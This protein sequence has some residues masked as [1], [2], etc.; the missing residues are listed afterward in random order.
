[1]KLFRPAAAAV[2]ILLAAAVSP[3]SAEES[4]PAPEELRAKVETA[5]SNWMKNLPPA[6]WRIRTNEEVPGGTRTM[7]TMAEKETI[8]FAGK[9]KMLKEPDPSSGSQLH[10]N[11][12]QTVRAVN[13][14]YWFTVTKKK[15][16]EEWDIVRVQ[17]N[18]SETGP[19]SVWQ[20]GLNVE[21]RSP[22]FAFREL[23]Y[24]FCI[25]GCYTVLDIL[26]YPGLV[27]ESVRE[28][29]D[30]GTS[31]TFHLDP[32][33]E[34]AAAFIPI[35]NGTVT[36]TG[37]YLIKDARFTMQ[38]GNLFTLENEY[39]EG[40][41][42]ALVKHTETSYNGETPGTKRT[43]S[44]ETG[45]LP[46]LPLKRFTLSRYGLPEPDYGYPSAKGVRIVL[47]TF[48]GVL[49]LIAL[50]SIFRKRRSEVKE[51]TP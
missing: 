24:P 26:R 44:I 37:G 39:S 28:E 30:G 22:F 49:I 14:R 15:S 16:D 41:N 23:F 42:P 46:R 8:F 20:D 21:K 3:V 17:R 40:V 27:L 25:A 47:I 11:S 31:F 34:S 32:I 50:F 36:L 1:M 38:G 51:E 6:E 45:K 9:T 13:P 19:L 4:V 12:I 2:L 43:V 7:Y 48:G 29:P 35:Q 10:P 33:D 18:E 5:F